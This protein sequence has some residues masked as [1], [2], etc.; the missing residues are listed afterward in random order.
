[1]FPFVDQTSYDQAEFAVV[2]ECPGYGC[3][4]LSWHKEEDSAKLTAQNFISIGGDVKVKPYPDGNLTEDLACELKALIL[5][6][7]SHESS[8]S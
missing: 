8:S 6:D 1:M 4:L 2:G 3:G 5:G 7:L